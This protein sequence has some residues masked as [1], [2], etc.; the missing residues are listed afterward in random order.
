MSFLVLAVPNQMAKPSNPL[1]D[2]FQSRSVPRVEGI[3]AADGLLNVLH[4]HGDV[5]PIQNAQEAA[6]EM[7]P[8]G[9]SSRR[10]RPRRGVGWPTETG[11]ERPAGGL[12]DQD[13]SAP[14][15][16]IRDRVP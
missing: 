2:H 14:P 12:I 5:P 6:D 3:D 10:R 7:V 4:A 15:P 9:R 11:S 13:F 8:A 16:Y 1:L